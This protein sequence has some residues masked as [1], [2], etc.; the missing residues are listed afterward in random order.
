METTLLKDAR[1]I[2]RHLQ[3]ER[4]ATEDEDLKKISECLLPHRGF[5]PQDGE[6]RESILQRGKKN[7]NPSSTLSLQRAAGGMTTGMTPEGQPWFGLTLKDPALLE[8]PGVREHLATRERLINALLRAGGFYQ[9]IHMCN[10]ELFG[11]GGLLLFADHSDKTLLRWECCTAGTYSIALDDEGMLD[12]TVRVIRRSPRQLEKKY[13]KAKLTKA[14]QELLD[15]DPYKKINVI[16][17]VRPRLDRDS[18]K[19]DSLN[20]PWQ[21]IMYEDNIDGD[22]AGT[23]DILK[24]GGYHENPYSYAPFERVGASD[25][26]MGRGHLM[27]GHDRQLNET[28]RLKVLCL[29]KMINPATKRPSTVKNRLNVGPGQE[30]VVSVTDTTAVGPIYEVPVQGYQ[31]ALQEIND[32]A[33]R[34]AAVSNADLFVTISAEMRPPDMT[35]GEYM[36]RKRE[37]LQMVAPVISIYEPVVLDH[38]IERANNVLDRAGMFPPPP[39]ALAEAG[40][41]EVEYISSVAKALRQFGAES[42]RALVIEVSALAKAQSEAGLKPTAMMKLDI[43]QAVDELARGIGAPA[44]IIIDDVAFEKA[45]AEEAEREASAA[46]MEQEERAVNSMSQLGSVPTEGTMASE[47]MQSAEK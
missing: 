22:D 31:Y 28:E 10:L 41:L 19:I 14:T 15:T 1:D 42:T 47:L 33:K 36:E 34:I 39:P 44:R 43:P 12:T 37:K 38:N 6:E 23:E 20:M 9:A 4:Q 30:T 13:G 17:V 5:F 27:V 3:G 11:F 40:T 46:E 25:Y 18:T 21:S 2:A 45:M 29:Q 26:G 24:E 16:H 8:Q 35:L 32:I 7:I